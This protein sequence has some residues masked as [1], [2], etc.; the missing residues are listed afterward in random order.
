MT[1]TVD[2]LQDLLSRVQA[3][4]TQAPQSLLLSLLADLDAQPNAIVSSYSSS[5]A[6]SARESTIP[7]SA[8]Q[9]SSRPPAAERIDT[10]GTPSAAPG[11]VHPVSVHAPAFVDAHQPVFSVVG[12]G[13]QT[14][15]PTFGEI[16]ARTLALRPR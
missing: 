14:S 8:T 1:Q 6:P 9:Y 10:A 7:P 3:N 11:P 16:M 2:E 5:P 4:R 12:A 15:R 13:E